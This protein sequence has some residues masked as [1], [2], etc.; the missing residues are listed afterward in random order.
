MKRE[1]WIFLL[2]CLLLGGVAE[3]AFFHAMPAV[4]FIVFVAALYWVFFWR[5]RRYAFANRRIGYLLLTCVWVLAASNAIYGEGMLQVLNL[6]VIP[7]LFV[8]HI[9]LITAK[10]RMAWYRPVF[11]IRVLSRLFGGLLYNSRCLKAVRLQW[12]EKAGSGAYRPLVKVGLGL[13]LALPFLLVVTLLL[14]S[15]DTQFGRLVGELPNWLLRVSL[16]EGLFRTVVVLAVASALFGFL[17]HVRTRE[18]TEQE[19]EAA[20]VRWTWD[21]IM[22]ATLLL[23]MNAVYLLFAAVQFQ[24]FFG[25]APQDLTYAEYARRGFAELVVVMVINL[26]MLAGVLTYTRMQG[27]LKLFVRL[28]LTLFVAATAVMLVSAFQRLSL[29]E[30]A[31][32]FTLLRLLA[33]SFMLLLGVLLAYTLARVWLEKLPLRHFYLIAGLLYYTGLSVA[34]LNGIVA[35]QNVE[36]FHGTGKIDV[37]YMG[38]LS[39]AGTSAL[40]D[41]YKEK[42]D[43]PQLRTVL[44]ERKNG[45]LQEEKH[46]QSWSLAKR[47][48]DEKLQRLQFGGQP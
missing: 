5:F 27:G 43:V 12:L 17:Q 28:L 19:R 10:G 48:V 11:L 8:I 32:G 47:N 3:L 4:S 30:A 39:Y 36:R 42:P 23:A 16:L 20:A 44:V 26:T 22:I 25:G 24:Y 21:G 15:A 34:D 46:W 13:L 14:S 2:L 6:L 40:I 9:V 35:W 7:A 31:Y 37:Y 18:Q 45:L 29:Y 33:H 41:V 38:S 1:D